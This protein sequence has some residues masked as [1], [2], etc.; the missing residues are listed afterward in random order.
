MFIAYYPDG[1][2][3][4]QGEYIADKKHKTWTEYDEQGS[5]KSTLVFRAGILVPPK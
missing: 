4:E 3:R 5:V 1:K 2:V